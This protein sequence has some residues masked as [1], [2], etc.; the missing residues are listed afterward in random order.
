MSMMT[1]E[2]VLIEETHRPS[3]NIQY[4]REEGYTMLYWSLIH[5]NKLIKIP[6]CPMDFL[7]D[8]NCNRDSAKGIADNAKQ[9]LPM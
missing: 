8:M 1:E 6:S 7:I 2:D 9:T 4:C 5:I 3:T